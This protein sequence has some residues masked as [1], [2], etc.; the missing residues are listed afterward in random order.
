MSHRWRKVRHVRRVAVAVIVTVS[1][2]PSMAGASGDQGQGKE[3]SVPFSSF[4]PDDRWC[5]PRYEQSTKNLQMLNVIGWAGL[6]STVAESRWTEKLGRVV[7]HIFPNRAPKGTT[8]FELRYWKERPDGTGEEGPYHA[9]YF[10]SASTRF[11]VSDADYG[12]RFSFSVVAL[13]GECLLYMTGVIGP[14]AWCPPGKYS[15]RGPYEPCR[16]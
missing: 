8:R 6:G 12:V 3:N 9:K 10:T 14:A 13:R 5:A 1:L 4:K 2:T 7:V 11:R 16:P 15:P